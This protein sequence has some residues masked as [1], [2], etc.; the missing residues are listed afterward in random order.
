MTPE[1]KRK[2]EEL[3]D[4]SIQTYREILDR[5]RHLDAD[6]LGDLQ[7][8]CEEIFKAGFEA[9]LR[10][11]GEMEL[12]EKQIRDVAKHEDSDGYFGFIEGARWAWAEFKR[13]LGHE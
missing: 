7:R 9:A 10:L 2:C 5:A 4:K 6:E 1:L 3:A 13:R 12:N 8:D 11:V